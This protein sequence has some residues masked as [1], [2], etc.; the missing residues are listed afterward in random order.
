VDGGVE[1]QVD[2]VNHA[3]VFLVGLKTWQEKKT[4]K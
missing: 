2:V 4:P 3:K 1:G